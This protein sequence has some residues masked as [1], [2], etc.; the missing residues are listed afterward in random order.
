MQPDTDYPQI[1][2]RDG[3]PVG[4]YGVGR[5]NG[6][7]SLY[8]AFD[9]G[10][11]AKLCAAGFTCDA[12]LIGIQG[13]STAIYELP[14]GHEACINFYGRTA[15]AAIREGNRMRTRPEFTIT[16]EVICL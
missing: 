11:I 3:V 12:V 7:V 10:V 9:E 16:E 4:C 14:A 8:A 5:A 15:K 6:K 13:I 1:V 2:R